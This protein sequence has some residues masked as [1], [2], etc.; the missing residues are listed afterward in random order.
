MLKFSRITFMC[1]GLLK[2]SLIFAKSHLL[3]VT[4]LSIYIFV[5]WNFYC[6]VSST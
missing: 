3:M 5:S 4:S 1:L 6:H 2:I